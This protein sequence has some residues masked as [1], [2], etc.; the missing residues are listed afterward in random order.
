MADGP[1]AVSVPPATPDQAEQGK[2]TLRR[3]LLTVNAG[4]PRGRKVPQGVGEG[5][6]LR[7]GELGE[8]EATPC[9]EMRRAPE[10]APPPD[11]GTPDHFGAEAQRAEGWWEFEGAGCTEPDEVEV[12]DLRTREAEVEEVDRLHAPH[13]RGGP[14]G[15]RRA[16]HRT[17][18]PFFR[19]SL[20]SCRACA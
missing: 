20:L 11:H 4:V 13:P 10:L 7:P 8:S 9:Y 12:L 2:T 16:R 18:L 17:L 15:Q 3:T 6:V 1:Q 14:L 5:R 19:H